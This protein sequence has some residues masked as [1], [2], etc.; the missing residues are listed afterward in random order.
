VERP[1]VANVT[2]PV[3]V[4]TYR[5]QFGPHFRFSDG[6]AIVPYLDALGV[7]WLYA[8]P[9]FRARPGSEH[10]YDVVDHNHL[11]PEIGSEADHRALV[12]ALRMRGMGHLVDFVPNHMG[13]GADNPWWRDVLALGT[14]S[15]YAHFFDIDWH[16]RSTGRGKVVLPFLGDHYGAV[17]ERGELTVAYDRPAGAFVLR[18]FEHRFPLA[19]ATYALVLERAATAAPAET[20]VAL[21][22]RAAAFAALRGRPREARI[23][24]ALRERI[25]GA[26]LELAATMAGD[27]AL[28]R[29]VDEA[30]DAYAHDPDRLDALVRAQHYR[31]AYWRTAADEINYRRFFDIND[32][33]GLRVEDA[34]VLAR[35]HQLVFAMIA[36]GRVGGL[37]IDHVDGLANPGGYVNLLVERA[38]ALGNPLYVVIEKILLGDER[39]RSGWLAAGT[40][41][42]DFMNLVLGLFVDTAAERGF[43][44]IYRRA[45]GRA[46]TFAE[47]AEAA[48]RRILRIDLASELF[49]LAD[50]LARIAAGDRRSSDFTTLGLRRALAD[51]IVAFPVYRTY[52]VDERVEDDDRRVIESA[53]AQAVA[54]SENPDAAL[55]DFIGA[56]I[57]GRLVNTPGARY[58]RVDVLR[59]AMRFQQYTGPVMAKSLEDTAFYRYVRLVALNEVGGEPARFG[60]SVAEFHAA[61]DER[62]RTHPHAMLATATHDHKRGE[63]TRLRIAALTE[64]P[65]EWSRA[66]ARWSR[67]NAGLRDAGRGVPSPVDEL[68]FYQTVVGTLPLAPGPPPDYADRLAAYAAK[69]AR[70]AKLHTSWT[71]PNASYE[72][73]LEAFVRGALAPDTPFLRD[74]SAF[75]AQLAPTAAVHGLAQVALKLT[76]PGVPDIYQG[77]ELWDFSLVDPDNRRPVDYERRTALLA[78]FR[79]RADLEALCAELAAAWPDGRI[80]LFVTWKLLQLR[81]ERAATFASGAYRALRVDAPNPDGVVAFARDD[82][83]VAA[84]R[85]VSARLQPGSIALDGE[86]GSLMTGLPDGRFR[87]ALDG[88]ELRA[89][90][91]GAIPLAQ[92][93]ALLPV[94]VLTAALAPGE[95]AGAGNV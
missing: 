86:A 7:G 36:D 2:T 85:L 75:V 16:A 57:D 93:F 30:C 37:R 20:A 83:L 41:G 77:C 90:A 61:N 81:R 3:P 10:G 26:Q 91:A 29:A 69:A 63:D 52:V 92:A 71:D 5:V 78:D 34:E 22:E 43:D 18:Y 39:L 24:A 66:I 44:R 87:H 1:L 65:A 67:M 47:E 32:L 54:R 11:N 46:A 80:K 89:D 33:A 14:L 38:Q 58:D 53:V 55:Y 82:V 21:R 49:V 51:T 25:A 73:A 6:E 15:T 74:A 84:P 31:P 94:A 12:G 62:A 9:Y 42:Y 95:R 88:R 45:T 28:A 70:E 56:A 17:L 8:S 50:A 79:T 68:L 27:A 72:S 4:S 19:P 59:F 48:K 40:T 76:A 35:T 13:I 64:F 60:R 23:R